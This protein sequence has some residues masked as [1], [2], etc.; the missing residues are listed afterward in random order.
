MILIKRIHVF[1]QNMLVV[2]FLFSSLMVFNACA[3]RSSETG[4]DHDG[5]DHVQT[6]PEGT[7][8]ESGD[9]HDHLHASGAGEGIRWRRPEYGR[10]VRIL[11]MTG[12]IDV[13]QKSSEWVTARIAGRVAA[14]KADIGDRVKTGD[15]LLIIDS[16][17]LLTLRE[18]FL[19][20]AQ[21]LRLNREAFSRAREL[22]LRQGIEAKTLLER[23]V[24]FR[25]SETGHLTARAALLR[26]NHD[27]TQL[28]RVVADGSSR[29]LVESFLDPLLVVRS[30]L[31]GVVSERDVEA[32]EW[33]TAERALQRI[34]DPGSVWGIFKA[35]TLQVSQLK[36]S[37]EVDIRIQ[38]E[39]KSRYKGQI[40]RISPQ[41]DSRTR[42]LSVRV[43]IENTD[44]GLR[45]GLFAGARL[46]M[47]D[48]RECLLAPEQARVMV[49][50]VGGVFVHEEDG[51]RFQ[52]LPGVE[53]DG[54]G[55]LILA[56]DWKETDIVVEGAFALKAQMLL[57][58]GAADAHSGHAH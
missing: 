6:H 17:E 4:L 20:S 37:G 58:S 32:G 21:E 25:I 57:A 54:E 48:S 51:F 39:M 46:R 27:P 56:D 13:D 53:T 50:G 34:T 28:D 41:V 47:M 42:M 29:E 24:Q 1:L 11:E 23:E 31:S 33:V 52:P 3:E 43:R 45:P 35:T 55:R 38:G 10:P 49:N 7:D 44:G 8:E 36:E 40:D 15:P 16:S 26:L 14:V 22:A 5:H 2:F 30:P 18:T 19:K 9:T 12:V